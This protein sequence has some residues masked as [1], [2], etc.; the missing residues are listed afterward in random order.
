MRQSLEAIAKG[1]GWRLNRYSDFRFSDIQTFGCSIIFPSVI[2]DLIQNLRFYEESI[3]RESNNTN[4]KIIINSIF[5][6]Y[7]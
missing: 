4:R 1:L 6:Y 7:H 2:L 5:D 3:S